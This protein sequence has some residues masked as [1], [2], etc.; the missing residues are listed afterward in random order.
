V[1]ALSRAADEELHVV[2]DLLGRVGIPVLCL[3]AEMASSSNL[4]IDLHTK[5]VRLGG[6]LIRPTVA[7]IRHFSTRAIPDSS[8][9][10]V[11]RTLV[12]DSWQ[13]IAQQVTV[14]SAASVAADNLGLLTQLDIARASGIK[15]PRTVVT[16]DLQAAYDFFPRERVVV[17]VV[18]HHFVE[19]RAGLLSG[20]FPKIMATAELMRMR[21]PPRLPLMVQEFIEHDAEIR[22]YYV[23]GEI[24]CFLVKKNDP[25]DI[26]IQPGRVEVRQLPSS[27]A[28]RSATERLARSMR[29]SYA[30]FDFLEKDGAL[31][32][33][34]ANPDGDW[35]WLEIRLDTTAVTLSVARMIR[36]IHLRH[37]H[38]PCPPAWKGAAREIDLVSFLSGQPAGDNTNRAG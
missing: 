38:L 11:L 20:V 21:H 2:Q 14:I 16:G 17:K 10:A 13:A 5:T 36:D 31:T 12:Q 30:A 25:A 33:L 28:I 1:L 34:E 32:F 4:L 8:G 19:A 3:D 29:L 26:W 9:N 6:C 15:V 23:A 27:A 35:R 22:A 18:G 37:L 24:I 7:W